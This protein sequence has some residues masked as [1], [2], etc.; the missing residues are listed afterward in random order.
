MISYFDIVRNMIKL[1]WLMF[2]FNNSNRPRGS[3]LPSWHDEISRGEFVN[4]LINQ[5][6]FRENFIETKR[7]WYYKISKSTQYKSIAGRDRL[8]WQRKQIDDLV[9]KALSKNLLLPKGNSSGNL[10]PIASEVYL[11]TD[12]RGRDFIKFFNF[13]E[14]CARE[15]GFMAS[16]ITAFIIGVGGTLLVVFF[17]EIQNL[18]SI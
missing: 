10:R 6:H 14:A 5:K 17:N 16:I 4:Y 2:Y 1:W 13:I 15:Y 9:D 3:N 7:R 8:L 11:T 18:L 12:W